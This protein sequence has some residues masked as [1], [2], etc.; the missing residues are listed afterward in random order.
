MSQHCTGFCHVT[1]DGQV[2]PGP[3]TSSTNSGVLAVGGDDG[4]DDDGAGVGADDAVAVLQE[5]LALV[6]AQLV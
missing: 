3:G 1:T 4:D 6:K 5:E 2:D